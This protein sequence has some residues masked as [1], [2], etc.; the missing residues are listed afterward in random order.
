MLYTAGKDEHCPD[1][2]EVV[3][4]CEESPDPIAEIDRTLSKKTKRRRGQRRASNLF[5]T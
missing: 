2:N 1:C 4:R 3:C 5:F